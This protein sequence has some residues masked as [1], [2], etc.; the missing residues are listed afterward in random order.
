MTNK[1]TCV[2]QS[3]PPPM[4]SNSQLRS[5]GTSNHLSE[6]PAAA[7]ASRAAAET[8]IARAITMPTATVSQPST[9]KMSNI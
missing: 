4:A 6:T 1:T 2:F 7:R 3:S 5:A 8:R 9:G